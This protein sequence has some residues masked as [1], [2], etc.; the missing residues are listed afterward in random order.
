MG[1]NILVID[2]EP[3]ISETLADLL[4]SVADKVFSANSAK[5]GLAIIEQ[6]SVH[7]VISDIM[8]PDMSGIELMKNLR[9][10]RFRYPVVFV[11]ASDSE[12]SLQKALEYGAADF[13]SKPFDTNELLQLVERLLKTVKLVA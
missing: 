5:D 11:S 8:M 6:N 4:S 10:R 7:L 13:I 1:Y 9:Q 2:D 12:E 3:D